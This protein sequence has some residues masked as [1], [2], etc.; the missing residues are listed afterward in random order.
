MNW[1]AKEL[2]HEDMDD[3]YGITNEQIQ[4]KGGHRLM[5]LYHN[6]PVRALTTIYPDHDW[7]LWKF[8]KIPPKFW[9]NVENVRQ[10]LKYLAARL[11]IT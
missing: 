9:D 8:S 1:V 3:W 11:S 4:K 7:Q 5:E 6:S 10:F 2:Q